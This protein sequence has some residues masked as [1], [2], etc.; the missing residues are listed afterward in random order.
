ML[1]ALLHSGVGEIVAVCIRYFGGT[2]LGTGGLSRAY[3]GG[4]KLLLESLPTVERF[5]R[6]R[7]QV[8]I[9]YPSVDA[10]RR[11]FEELEAIVEVEEYGERVEYIVAIPDENAGKLSKAIAGITKG[12]GMINPA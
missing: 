3:S 9:D 5:D 1:N 10:A 6:V 11:L 4:V 2:K 12:Q 7:L 8:V